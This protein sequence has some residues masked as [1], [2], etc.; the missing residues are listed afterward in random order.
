[1]NKAAA[2]TA[3]E[4]DVLVEEFSKKKELL[5]GSFKDVGT[6]SKKKEA[7]VLVCNWVNAVGG[8]NRDVK[9]VKKKWADLK[10]ITKKKVAEE[11][12]ERIKTGGGSLI[13]RSITTVE[14][15]IISVICRIGGVDTSGK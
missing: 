4:K 13:P 9:Q 3:E 8:H 10:S 14:E 5:E 12:R 7:W 11:K 6:N 1:M 2:F 15:K